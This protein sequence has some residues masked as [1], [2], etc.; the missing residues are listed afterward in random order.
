MAYFV[1][2]GKKGHGLTT[3]VSAVVTVWL[4]ALCYWEYLALA[5]A[6]GVVTTILLSFKLEMHRFAQQISSQDIYAT[7]KFAVITTIILPVLP[8]ESLGPAPFDVLNPHRI[9]LMVVLI[10]GISFLGYVLMKLVDAQRGI[11]LTGLLGGLGVEHGGD[12]ELLRAQPAPP[13]IGTQLCLCDYSG[14]GGDVCACADRS[15]G[16]QLGIV[17]SALDSDCSG[18]GVAMIYVGVLNYAQHSGR[19]EKVIIANP[20][21]LSTAL[22]FGLLYGL[23]LLIARVGQLYWSDTGIYLSSALSGIA[24]VDAITLSLSQLSNQTGTVTLQTAAR[25]IV[26]ATMVNTGIKAGIV[27]STGR[28]FCGALCCLACC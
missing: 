5:A 13:R 21:E 1:T 11:G 3:E 20:F 24:D 7:L 28:Q 15:G 25:A 19:Q 17:A 16:G 14:L 10:S 9:W 2:T 8:N 12:D 27:L 18:P 26:L 23:I 22:K 6:I 4:G